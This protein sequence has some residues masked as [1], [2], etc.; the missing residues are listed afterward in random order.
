MRIGFTIIFN[1]LKHLL[2]NNYAEYLLS[3]CLD[4]WVVVD[5]AVENN[6]WNENNSYIDGYNINGKSIDGTIDYLNKLKKKYSNLI[7]IE[8]NK[9]W[10]DKTEKQN[11]AINEIK[12]ITNKCYLWHIDIDEQ[13]L[14]EDMLEAEN[15]LDKN[16]SSIAKFKFNQFI[17]KNLIASGKSWGGNSVKRLFKWSGENFLTHYYSEIEDENICELSQK[18][19]HYSYYFDFDVYF[20]SKWY[21]NDKKIYD[22]WKKLQ[23]KNI[24]E[25][26]LSINELFKDTISSIGNNIA[27]LDSIIY[28][29]NDEYN[30]KWKSKFIL[31]T[32]FFIHKMEIRNEEFKRSI[33]NNINNEN[34]KKIILFFE[35][36]NDNILNEKFYKFLTNEKIVIVPVNERSTYQELIDYSNLNYFNEICIIA[37]TDIWFDKTIE[38]IYDI[39]LDN[40]VVCLTRYTK[41]DDECKLETFVGGTHDSW[42]YKA[43]LNIEANI[44]MGIQYCEI[45]LH[46]ILNKNNFK[47]INYCYD[48]KSYHEHYTSDIKSEDRINILPDK[49]TYRT[50]YLE[51][52][53]NPIK[54]SYISYKNI[55]GY[56]LLQGYFI[57]SIESRNE[58]FLKCLKKNINNPAIKKIIL[59]FE[60]LTEEIY[61]FKI[62]FL[63]N[64]KIEIIPIYNR[65][66]YKMIIDY[67]NQ[68]LKNE[69]CIIAN[70]D[71]W[72]DETI[73]KLNYIDFNNTMVCLTRYDSCKNYEFHTDTG[74]SHDSWI[75]KT[76]IKNFYNNIQMGILG[77]DSYFNQKVGESGYKI[78]C[79]SYDIKSYHEHSDN[80]HFSLTRN[81]TLIDGKT[82]GHSNPDWK[83]I[84]IKSEHLNSNI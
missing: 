64:E 33:I 7:F 56:I 51:K 16:N 42:V 12:K 5:G 27:N 3:T 23:E 78:L 48:I 32:P 11:A 26:P 62:P 68:Y 59:F 28:Y 35:N 29:K 8:T 6:H 40:T 2:H 39:N 14:Y 1:G 41:K 25:F 71:I 10:S 83:N 9:K 49:S 4:Y 69:I 75:F 36:F 61:L 34:I 79:P 50:Q 47:L 57:H 63:K 52:F 58:E 20:K 44:K 21:Y 19:N 72:F 45:F 43:P 22:N 82:Y 30:F 80:D 73:E 37:N 74:V 70:T 77:C 13:W 31:L 60:N 55:T 76:P 38:K 81:N 17:G 24:D 18:F 15:E 84:I 66:T 67:C 54:P 46:S 53:Y 65:P